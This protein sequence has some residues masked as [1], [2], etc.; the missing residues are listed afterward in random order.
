[1]NSRAYYRLIGGDAFA[2]TVTNDEYTFQVSQTW[3][4]I[5]PDPRI[6]FAGCSVTQRDV[7]SFLVEETE[8]T[9]TEDQGKTEDGTGGTGIDARAM[10]LVGSQSTDIEPLV[11]SDC[12][13]AVAAFGGAFLALPCR[14]EYVLTGNEIAP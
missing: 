5:E 13:P 10:T 4:V 1:D 6:G 14:I 3:T 2:G 11:G 12:R 8:D 7:F 9:S